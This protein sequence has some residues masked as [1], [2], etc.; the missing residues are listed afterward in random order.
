[1]KL[2][3]KGDPIPKDSIENFKNKNI[4]FLHVLKEEYADFLGFNIKVLKTLESKSKI[5]NAKISSFLGYVNDIVLKNAF[6]NQLDSESIDDIVNYSQTALDLVCKRNLFAQLLTDLASH[7]DRL[8]AHSMGTAVLAYLMAR[9]LGW[10][11]EPTLFKIFLAGV[12]H[13]IG[14]K[15]IP[16][17]IINKTSF[18]R[19]DEEQKLFQSHPFKAMEMLNSI[20]GIPEEVILAAYQHH[21]DG[22]GK[23]FP[24]K[25]RRSRTTPISRLIS[26]ADIFDDKF[27]SSEE[28]SLIEMKNA[29][30]D[31]EK[32]KPDAYD[33]EFMQA[34]K[35]IFKLK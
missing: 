31:V 19:T 27:L 23:G 35:T 10:S 13:D 3:Q 14:L 25:L 20:G 28:L 5:P 12:L 1:M 32:N 2:A 16:E 21:E 29:L 15:D 4:K 33:K 17:A 34:L 8:F 30:K 26:V 22:L 11:N 9:K 18:L 7:S 24:Q 6:V